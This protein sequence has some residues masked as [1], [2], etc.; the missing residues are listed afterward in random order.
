[1]TKQQLIDEISYIL[2]KRDY[3]NHPAI[4]ETVI[5]GVYNQL[6]SELSPM[7]LQRFEFYS[8]SYEA[9]VSLD[10]SSQR[11]YA[12]LPVPVVNLNRSQG[13]VLGVNAKDGTG[14]RYY[15]TTEREQR[16]TEN[17]ES[18]LYDRYSGYYVNRNR[19]WFT[20]MNA[21]RAS[22]GVRLNLAP[23]FRS[24]SATDEVPLP[25]GRDYELKQLVIDMI[26]NQQIIDLQIDEKE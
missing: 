11:Y 7:D 2:K 1:M 20:N 9:N 24:F 23:Q 17:L 3:Q 26:T 12:D 10:S 14:H 13:G 6:I 18:G 16:Y 8:K 21:E 25:A 4:I 22:A 15:P 5:N 19:V